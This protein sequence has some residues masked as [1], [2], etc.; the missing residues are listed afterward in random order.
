MR[1]ANLKSL[2]SSERVRAE[3][4]RQWNLFSPA[5]SFGAYVG[6]ALAAIEKG[7]NSLRAHH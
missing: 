6:T 5:S 3:W 2:R 7:K 1:C 4:V